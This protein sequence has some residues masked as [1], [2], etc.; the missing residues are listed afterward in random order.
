[1]GRNSICSVLS[2]LG[3]QI[4]SSRERQCREIITQTG[5]YRWGGCQQEK[6]EDSGEQPWEPKPDLGIGGSYLKEA[7]LRLK[8]E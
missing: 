6:L 2:P 8:D 7:Q 4:L 1:M 5:S 3:P